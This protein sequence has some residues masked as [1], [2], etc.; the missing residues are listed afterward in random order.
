MD[1]AVLAGGQYASTLVDD[2]RVWRERKGGGGGGGGGGVTREDFEAAR[3]RVQG[4]VHYQIVDN[5]LYRQPHC[6]IG[7]R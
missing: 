5:V 7:P 2:L 1:E 4:G 3:E 6:I